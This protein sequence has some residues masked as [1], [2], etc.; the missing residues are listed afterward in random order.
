M[1]SLKY[2]AKD[3]YSERTITRAGIMKMKGT[4]RVKA[5]STYFCRGT[6]KGNVINTQGNRPTEACIILVN[7]YIAGHDVRFVLIFNRDIEAISY[8]R[9]IL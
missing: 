1:T 2:P 8:T 3:T 9:R 4:W 6:T 5:P 7:I